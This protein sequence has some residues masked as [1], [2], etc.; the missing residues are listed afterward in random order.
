MRRLAWMSWLLAVLLALV[1]GW[2]S[3]QPVMPNV[4]TA[5]VPVP[6]LVLWGR[7]QPGLPASVA[8]APEPLPAPPVTVSAPAAVLARP[9]ACARLGIFPSADWATDVGRLLLPEA[10]QQG[11]LGWSVKAYSGQRYYVVFTGLDAD[12]LAQRLASRKALLRRRVT[13]SAR[14]EGCA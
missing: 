12:A 10:E 14:P 1:I 4:A 7:A 2:Q 5:H 11:G 8:L 9:G 13:A 6:E 3:R